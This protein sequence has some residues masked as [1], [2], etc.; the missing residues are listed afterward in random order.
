MRQIKV[1]SIFLLMAVLLGGLVPV[2][3]F[4]KDEDTKRV[5]TNLYVVDI[6]TANTLLRGT[7]DAFARLYA[8]DGIVG[9][10]VIALND[11]FLF[12]GGINMEN[13]IGSGDVQAQTP[14]FIAKWR[15]IAEDKNIPACAIGYDGLGYGDYNSD[16]GVW[17]HKQKGFYGA[18]TK[19]FSSFGIFQLTCGMSRVDSRVYDP[20]RDITAFAGLAAAIIKEVALNVEYDDWFNTQGGEFNVGLGYNFDPAMKLEFDLEDIGRAGDS[21][22]RTLKIEYCNYI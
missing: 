6:P 2:S 7:Y 8:P 18:V 4:G 20:Q 19:E 15:I 22:E 9:R 1:V 5:A 16:S 17:Q 11:Q 13:I 3:V 12:G 21:L 10:F 14:R